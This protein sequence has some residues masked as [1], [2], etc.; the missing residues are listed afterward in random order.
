ML[1]NVSH[2][3]TCWEDPL[4]WWN[5]LSAVTHRIAV[6]VRAR[7]GSS[8]FTRL[9]GLFPP[10][11][12]LPQHTTALAQTTRVGGSQVTWH[13]ETLEGSASTSFKI[14][15]LFC[16]IPALFRW[17][18]LE[19]NMKDGNLSVCVCVV[20]NYVDLLVYILGTSAVAWK[21][22]SETSGKQPNHKF[23]LGFVF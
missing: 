14:F 19:R 7:S 20:A 5:W 23:T 11:S 16:D 9:P 13:A 15:S 10:H 18:Q 3:W 17:W 1:P 2:F 8:Q 6:F 4:L 12:P 21:K 22:L